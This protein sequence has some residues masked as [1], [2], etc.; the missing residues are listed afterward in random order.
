MSQRKE[1]AER[2]T[3]ASQAASL[4]SQAT[5]RSHMSMPH[6]HMHPISAN[7]KQSIHLIECPFTAHNNIFSYRPTYLLAHSRTTRHWTENSIAHKHNDLHRTNIV[8][9]LTTNQWLTIQVKLWFHKIIRAFC[10]FSHFLKCAL[11]MGNSTHSSFLLFCLASTEHMWF[12]FYF[13]HFIYKWVMFKISLIV[14]R[15]AQRSIAIWIW[16]PVVAAITMTQLVQLEE[17]FP[18]SRGG[19]EEHMQPLLLLL[20]ILHRRSFQMQPLILHQ[21]PLF[22]DAN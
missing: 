14:V 16:L 20:F 4:C 8:F 1:R 11:R 19:K 21:L 3:T 17:R 18:S 6:I 10:F 7:L 15:A 9:H 2:S 13:L 5:P 12:C 22:L